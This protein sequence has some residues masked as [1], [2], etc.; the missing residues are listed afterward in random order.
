LRRDN[1]QLVT[2]PIKQVTPTGIE[3]TSGAIDVDVVVFATGFT[4]NRPLWPI[5]VWGRDGVDVRRELDAKPEAYRGMAVA[6]CPN[7]LMTYG[8]HGT[9]AHG[10]NGMLF[11]ECAVT[12]AV[13]CLRAMFD[14]GWRRMEVK[15]EAVR[16][17]RDAMAA[18]VEGFVFS[19]PGVSNWFRGE[20]DE[21]TAVVPKKLIDIWNESKRPDLD[22]YVGAST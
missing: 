4:T 19:V 11:A 14:H 20:R 3:T 10:G 22:A 5:Q 18:E 12:Y 6:H 16:G 7:L 1:V 21:A 13:E 15:P 2:S 9:P 8:P 17:Y